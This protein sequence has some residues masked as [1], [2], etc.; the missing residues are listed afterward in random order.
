MILV[1]ENLFDVTKPCLLIDSGVISLVNSLIPA[2]QI[3]G[4]NLKRQ[5][6]ASELYDR[7]EASFADFQINLLDKGLPDGL[8]SISRG[9]GIQIIKKLN[10]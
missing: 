5:T 7:Y 3:K 4:K 1:P 8:E 2:D 6:R 10:I 9:C